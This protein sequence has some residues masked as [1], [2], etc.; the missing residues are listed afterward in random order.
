[1]AQPKKA[2]QTP[3]A[4]QTNVSND[5][6]VCRSRP[7]AVELAFGHF[8]MRSSEVHRTRRGHRGN[9]AHDPQRNIELTTASLNSVPSQ[10]CM[11]TGM[12]SQRCKRAN[13]IEVRL[14]LTV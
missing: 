13:F 9:G 10:V 11:P 2:V 1:M 14:S 8:L 3:L 6:L 7:A 12:R 4:V 5:L